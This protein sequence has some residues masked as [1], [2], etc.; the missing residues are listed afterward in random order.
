MPR[1]NA[2]AYAFLDTNIYLH[3]KDFDNID[4]RDVL[5]YQ[6]VC[7]VVSPINITELEKFKYDRISERRQKR[8]RMLTR[9]ITDLAFSFES[10]EDA[11]I[12][13][14]DGVVLRVLTTS[15]EMAKY[16]GLQPTEGDDQLIAAVLQFTKWNVTIPPEDIIL[17]A[18]DSGVLLK[19]RAN[20]INVRTLIDEYRLPDE[21]TLDQQ[22]ITL[23]ERRLN[24][25]ENSQPKLRLAFLYNNNPTA[26]LRAEI[27]LIKRPTTEELGQLWEQKQALLLDL[28]KRRLAKPKSTHNNTPQTSAEALNEVVESLRL[29]MLNSISPAEYQR[30]EQEVKEYS[31]AYQRFLLGLYEWQA[32]VGRYGRVELAVMN[33]GTSPATGLVV[34]FS[35][36]DGLQ[37]ETDEIDDAPKKP[38]E[39]RLPMTTLEMMGNLGR[40]SLIAPTIYDSLYRMNAVPKPFDPDQA[41]PKIMSEHSIL[42]EWNRSKALHQLPLQ[43]TPIWILFP[44]VEGQQLYNFGYRIF[45][46]NVPVPVEGSLSITAVGKSAKFNPS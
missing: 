35:V 23:L 34:R 19:G 10:G 6:N 30:Y 29:G 5:G 32:V 26:G 8:A 39:P 18:D 17:I 42:L 37:V 20:K 45:A 21:A 14:R 22:K 7:L 9:K 40:A 25:I 15:P 13:G 33:E 24:E 1:R 43:L 4:W 27:L 11:P 12:Q 28:G 36:P 2:T 16:P 31:A 46:E 41:G 38:E 3:F 44:T